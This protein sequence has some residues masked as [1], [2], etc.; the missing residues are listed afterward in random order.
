[1]VQDTIHL[2]VKL[3]CKFLHASDIMPMGKHH[4]VSRGHIADLIENTS[5]GKHKLTASILTQKDKMNFRSAQNLC[6]T[7]VCEELACVAGSEATITFLNMMRE[8]CS[9]FLD[10]TLNASQR[11]SR[12]FKWLFFVRLWRKWIDDTD[13][14]SLSHNFITSNS[15]TCMELNAH[16]LILMVRKLRDAEEHNLFLP[17]LFSSQ[18]CEDFFRKSRAMSPTQST[19]VTFSIL[20]L[21]HKTR[22]TDF[23]SQSF[24]KLANDFEFP[25][26]KKMYQHQ[27][28]QPHVSTVLP[29][30][31]EIEKLI[32]KALQDAIEEA[33]AFQIIVKPKSKS[34]SKFPVC[35]LGSDLSITEENEEHFNDFDVDAETTED[36]SEDYSDFNTFQ[37]SDENTV[38][39]VEEDLL[40]CCTGSLG[41]KNFDNVSI[42]SSS[43]FVAVK[44][45]NGKQCV[46]KKSSLIWLLSSGDTRI[47]SDRLL[48]VQAAAVQHKR[49][50]TV[51]NQKPFKE[52]TLLVGNWYAF[53]SE[54]NSIAIGRVLA[55]SYLSGSTWRDQV[56][57]RTSA[58]VQ[59]PNEQTKRGLG[60][61]CDWYTIQ[62]NGKLKSV[63]MDIHGYYPIEKYICTIPRPVINN[64]ILQLPC[65]LREIKRFDGT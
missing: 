31:Y 44:D 4:I 51:K 11:I 65:P 55:F 14:Y 2:L 24:S 7:I 61:L 39:D 23:L 20:E 58:P 35:P 6:D 52:D 63:S 37:D 22:R 17:W 19:M 50:D 12:V 18:D 43:P 46:I 40:V 47:S 32:E 34:K 21:Q 64:Q 48:R 1:M 13:G 29:E 49:N 15:Y 42:S 57:S 53:S 30:D 54:D 41:L 28:Q 5:K 38:N 45:G 25:R 33:V 27:N 9:A 26:L 59:A 10:V 36:S 56:Y 3:K 8:F 60:C 62:K 16:A